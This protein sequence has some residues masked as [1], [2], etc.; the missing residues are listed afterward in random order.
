MRAV[1]LR[2]SSK[3]TWLL[4]AS[5]SSLSKP[6]YREKGSHLS[7]I[8]IPIRHWFMQRAGIG[9]PTPA[10]SS[11]FQ[12]AATRCQPAQASSAVT[13]TH[14]PSRHITEQPKCP[15]LTFRCDNAVKRHGANATMPEAS[16]PSITQRVTG[17]VKRAL[18]FPLHESRPAKRSRC[19]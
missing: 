9:P 1:Q 10:R 8:R 14:P 7:G 16:R 15:R 18:G 13:M 2:S 4:R 3:F 19:R 12:T 17:A 6:I 5:S 11:D